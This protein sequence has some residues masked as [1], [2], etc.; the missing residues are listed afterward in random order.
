MLKLWCEYD[1]GQDLL[2][3]TTE[4]AAQEWFNSTFFAVETDSEGNFDFEWWGFV[5][6]KTPYQNM[7]E[8]GLVSLMKLEVIGPRNAVPVAPIL[9]ANDNDVN[10]KNNFLYA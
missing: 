3:F 6:E 4:K 9:A 10:R 7:D 8:Q 1:Y 5:P 2:V